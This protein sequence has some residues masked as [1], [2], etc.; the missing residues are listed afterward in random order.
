[1]RRR[2]PTTNTYLPIS[3]HMVR[4]KAKVK[5][6]NYQS[7]GGWTKTFIISLSTIIFIYW[8]RRSIY[9]QKNTLNFDRCNLYSYQQID[10]LKELNLSNCGLSHLPTDIELWSRFTYVTKLDINNNTLSGK[11]AFRYSFI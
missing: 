8:Y 3:S 1:M 2:S 5:Q 11:C 10:E 9:L 7:V 4:P 6:Y